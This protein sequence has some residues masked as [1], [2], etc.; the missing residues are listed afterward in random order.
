MIGNLKYKILFVIALIFVV[1][2]VSSA[3][4]TRLDYVKN[5]LISSGLNK[6]SVNKVLADKRIR[7]YQLKVVAYKA[8]NWQI[9]ESKLLSQS[10]VQTGAAYIKNNQAVFDK[11]EQDFGVKKEVLA[12]IIAIETDFGKNLGGY[13]IFNVIYSRLERWPQTQWKGQA[14]ELVA[15]IKYCLKSKIDCFGI[16]GSYAGAFGLVQFMPSS[17]LAYGIDGNKNGIIELSKP[18]DAIPS[19]ANFLKAHG[20]QTNQLKALTSYYGSPVGYPNIVLSYASL[21]SK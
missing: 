20:W 18:A 12:G 10:L 5:Q 1:P 9:I 14:G 4:D 19:A 21:L 8:P 2:A 13:P 7:L 16:K 11:A 3:S 15:L 6:T 17:L